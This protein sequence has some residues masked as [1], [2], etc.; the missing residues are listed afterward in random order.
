MYYYLGDMVFA[1]TGEIRKPMYEWFLLEGRPVYRGGNYYEGSK[2]SNKAN[3]IAYFKNV[4]SYPIL[5]LV[6]PDPM[7]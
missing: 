2:Q 6:Q 3:R 7:C 5:K 4:A 1:E